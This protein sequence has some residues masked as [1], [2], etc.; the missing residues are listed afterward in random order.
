MDTCA[1][2]H[3]CAS[4]HT[5]LHMN[6]RTGMALP[7]HYCIEKSIQLRAYAHAHVITP[8]TAH[9]RARETLTATYPGT[10]RT[11]THL[12]MHTPEHAG[13]CTVAHTR[14]MHVNTPRQTRPHWHTWAHAQRLVCSQ[15]PGGFLLTVHGPKTICWERL[16][17]PKSPS[18][19]VNCSAID[20]CPSIPG[21][22]WCG[23]PSLT[24]G[25]RQDQAAWS[26]FG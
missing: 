23:S 25:R 11:Q 26:C 18:P 17:G 22:A 8:T 19:G 6:T 7:L 20:G 14:A 2:E 10:A 9:P 15:G 4:T 13:T 3:T 21:K 5:C 24:P 16:I 1:H 12:Q